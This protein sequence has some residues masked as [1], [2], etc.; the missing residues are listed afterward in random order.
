MLLRIVFY[1]LFSTSLFALSIDSNLTEIDLLPYSEIYIDRTQNATIDT[2]RSKPFRPVTQKA[3]GFGYSPKFHI[4]IRFTLANDTDKPIRKIIE[5]ANPLT[6]HVNFYTAPPGKLL[7]EEG[8]LSKTGQSVAINPTLDITLAPHT[9]RTYY[10]EAYSQVTTL[11]VS[12]RLYQPK[13][14]YKKEIRHQ[15]IT[16]LFFGVMGIVILY[17]FI[18]FV[19]TQERSYLYYVLFFMGITV[20]HLIYKGIAHLYI[21]PQNIMTHLIEYSIFIVAFPAFFLALFMKEILALKHYPSINKTLNLYLV[22]FPFLVVLFSKLGYDN[23]RN[24]PTM[25]LLC[26][27]LVILVIMMFKKN[28]YAYMIALGWFLFISSAIAMQLSS[29]GKY[30]L[31]AKYPYYAE[32]ALI[33]EAILFSLVLSSRIKQLQYE[34]AKAKEKLYLQQ[35]QEKQRLKK[36]VEAKT[37]DLVKMVDEKQ[38]LLR[39]LNHRV[40]NNLQT[41]LSF[42]RLQGGNISDNSARKAFE[43]LEHRI[44][45]IDH[46]H[47]LLDPQKGIENIDTQ[48]YFSFIVKHLQESFQ[49][50][51]IKVAIEAGAVLKFNDALH[52]GIIL[53]EAVT[54]AYQHAFKGIA[55]G[56]IFV[57]LL[58]NG[59]MYI[60]RIK[61]SGAGYDPKSGTDSL[62]LHLI[63]NLVLSHLEGTFQITNTMQGT[64]IEIKWREREA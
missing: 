4:W 64:A 32:F 42:I 8:L 5:Y 10:I 17:N 44:L 35:T 38:L 59:D 16:A 24:L 25:V 52:C 7:K 57:E 40:K 9:R 49:M 61:D 29:M 2:V 34:N 63:E 51:H 33:L 3:L 36:E 28:R 62:G 30:D 21:V 43:T 60:F 22:L 6:S 31:F 50:P 11:L 23:Y 37:A 26:L 39:E 27:I 15:F 12:L 41:I 58:Q 13:T 19:M 1:I 45:S 55:N 53:N 14:F 20:H 18:I 48:A 47:K 46:L 54:N 56:T